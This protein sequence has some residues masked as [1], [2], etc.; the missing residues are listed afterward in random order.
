MSGRLLTEKKGRVGYLIFD[1]ELRRNAVT[2]RMWREIPGAVRRFAEDDD[3]RVVVMRGAGEVAFVAGADI[4]EFENARTGTEAQA[5]DATNAAA[6]DALAG[7]DKPLLAMIH[8]FCV[9][10]G[11]AIALQADLRYGA[12]DSVFAIPAARLGL[13]YAM[14]GLRTLIQVV[15]LPHA[16]EIFLTAQRFGA[17]DALRMGLLNGVLRKSELEQ[18]VCDAAERIADNAPLTLRAAKV[19]MR[20]LMRDDPA[21]RDEAAVASAISACYASDDYAEGVSAFLEKR[22][23]RFQGR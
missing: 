18:H 20:E 5:Y 23:A 16:K 21:A 15:G 22:R 3:V 13:G 14:T 6:F 2:A 12:D 19:A 10:G 11:V 4:S 1:H 7:F 9:G 8:G 17:A